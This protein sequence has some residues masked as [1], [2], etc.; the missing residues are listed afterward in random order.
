MALY[1]PEP[2]KVGDTDAEVQR[3]ISLAYDIPGAASSAA[4]AAIVTQ[5]TEHAMLPAGG[6]TMTMGDYNLDV[7][8]ETQ[9]YSDVISQQSVLNAYNAGLLPTAT[10]FM[11]L[12]GG[13]GLGTI[14]SLIAG[15]GTVVGIAQALGFGEG[16]GILNNNLLGGDSSAP[17]GLPAAT[18]FGGPGLAEPGPGS[19]W[20][21]QKEWHVNYSWGKLQYY[22]IKR[23]TSR[24]RYI[25]MWNSKT[26]NWK[27][28][29]FNPPKLAVIGKNM[30]SHKNIT[31]LRHNLKRHKDDARTILKLTDPV[32]Y[33][34]GLGYRNYK[35]R[36]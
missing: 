13:G 11:P 23:P 2:I 6:N 9:G 18:E 1:Y 25:A 19:G 7:L 26:G 22:L 21:L 34:K 14:G 24:T 16:G 8:Q 12:S 31:R 3:K 29:R 27:T 10:G 5:P 28:W 17:A 4:A 32:G 15:A 36:R 33:A 20:V 35:K 30:P